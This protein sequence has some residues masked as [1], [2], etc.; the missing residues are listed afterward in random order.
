MSSLTCGVCGGDIGDPTDIDTFE[1]CHCVRPFVEK[2]E[3]EA[4][5]PMVDILADIDRYVGVAKPMR[6][7]V[8]LDDDNVPF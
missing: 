4:Y 6:E 2:D 8:V 7:H 1:P 5:D 3:R